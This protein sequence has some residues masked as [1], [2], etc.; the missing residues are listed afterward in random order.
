MRRHPVFGRDDMLDLQRRT[1]LPD[2]L[3][4][5][6]PSYSDK[7]VADVASVK[8]AVE[9]PL[10][11]STPAQPQ[12]KIVCRSVWN[13]VVHFPTVALAAPIPKAE[14]HDH[15]RCQVHRRADERASWRVGSGI[16]LAVTMWPPR[17]PRWAIDPCGSFPRDL[18]G[19]SSTSAR[20]PPC[21]AIARGVRRGHCARV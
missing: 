5:R 21:D 4:H 8:F 18:E 16:S 2:R 11:I 7:V 9:R 17:P 6:L 14:S 3:K 15:A 19:P 13:V 1:V 10:L 20:R 12:I